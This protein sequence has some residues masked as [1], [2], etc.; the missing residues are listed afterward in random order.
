MECRTERTYPQSNTTGYLIGNGTKKQVI[1]L[2]NIVINM[3]S[4]FMQ[5]RMK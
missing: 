2:H 4:I 3:M 5:N 1:D